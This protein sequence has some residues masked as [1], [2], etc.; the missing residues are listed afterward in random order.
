ML[1]YVC[2][3]LCVC[4]C[5][6]K[7]AYVCAVSVSLCSVPMCVVDLCQGKLR[8][9]AMQH[10]ASIRSESTHTHTQRV[11]ERERAND[12]DRQSQARYSSSL[13]PT[14]HTAS[15]GGETL[16]KPPCPG[17]CQDLDGVE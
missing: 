12:S 10:M 1:T 9:I 2:V 14:L 16:N 13:Q 11:R 5:V 15:S 7:C 4:V 3:C 8:Y 6:R 17:A